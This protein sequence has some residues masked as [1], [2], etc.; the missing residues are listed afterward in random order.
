LK[1]LAAINDKT[2]NLLRDTGNGVLPAGERT[3]DPFRA[4]ALIECIDTAL[5]GRWD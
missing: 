3:N 1:P 2:W 5:K 4:Q